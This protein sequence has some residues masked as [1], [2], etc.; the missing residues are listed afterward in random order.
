MFSELEN[1]KVVHPI[2]YLPF[3]EPFV[4]GL[5]SIGDKVVF[6]QTKCI[7]E[8]VIFRSLINFNLINVVFSDLSEDVPGFGTV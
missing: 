1:P 6:D 4:E 8:G 7:D 2:Y 5:V 3:K